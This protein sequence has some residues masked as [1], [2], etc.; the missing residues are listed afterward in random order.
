MKRNLSLGASIPA[1]ILKTLGIL[2]GSGVVG[3]K[4]LAQNREAR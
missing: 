1:L 4:F 3:G 2:C